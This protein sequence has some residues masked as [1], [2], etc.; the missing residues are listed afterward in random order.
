MPSEMPLSIGSKLPTVPAP[1]VNVV[2][3]TG[4][5]PADFLLPRV[6][7]AIDVV[8][9]EVHI[10]NSRDLTEVDPHDNGFEIGREVRDELERLV[11]RR[12]PA[13]N[14]RR[15]AHSL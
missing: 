5:N 10:A 13:G 12:N 7:D 2:V 1:E 9:E 8:D 6:E 14:E 4:G 15:A 3:R 11:G